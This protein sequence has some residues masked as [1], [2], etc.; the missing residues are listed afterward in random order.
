MIENFN[1]VINGI[2]KQKFKQTS[3]IECGD[4]LDTVAT[5]VLLRIADCVGNCGHRGT[6]RGT[7]AHHS[8]LFGTMV[9]RVFGIDAGPV[10]GNGDGPRAQSLRQLR[11]TTWTQ[12]TKNNFMRGHGIICNQFDSV[13]CWTSSLKTAP[14]GAIFLSFK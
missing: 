4:Y 5:F 7:L 6:G 1:G 10:L 12:N 2:Y 9:V 3:G 8:A 13:L 14:L 11:R